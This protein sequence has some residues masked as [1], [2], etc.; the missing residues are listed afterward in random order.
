MVEFDP[1]LGMTAPPS[2]S[3]LD[4]TTFVPQ[5]TV[6]PLLVITESEGGEEVGMER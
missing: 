5:R 4:P 2:G 1:M 6:G 3:F